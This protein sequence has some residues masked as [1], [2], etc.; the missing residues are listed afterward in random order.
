M[1]AAFRRRLLVSLVIALLFTSAEMGGAREHGVDLRIN[2]RGLY[3]SEPKNVVTTSIEATNTAD[4]AL[5]FLLDCE[6]P[7]NWKLVTPSF[8]FHLAPNETNIRPVC[9]FIPETAVAGTYEIICRVHS[10]VYPAISDSV[11]LNVV[12]RSVSKLRAALHTVPETVIAGRGYEAVFSVTNAGNTEMSVLFDVRSGQ[13]IPH[14]IEPEAATLAPG[15]SRAVTVSVETDEK[16]RRRLRHHLVL[17]ARSEDGQ[18]TGHAGCAVD[19]IPRITG[20]ADPFHRIPSELTFKWLGKSN[21]AERAGVQGEFFGRGMLSEDGEE[22]IAFL[23]RGPDTLDISSVFGRRDRYWAEYRGRY[24]EVS[25]GDHHVSLSPLIE[26]HFA[27]RGF[28]FGLNS[29]DFGLRGYHMNTRWLAA[30]EKETAVHLDYRLSGRHRLGINL[31]RHESGCKAAHMASLQGKTAPFE[32]A[33]IEFEAAYGKE[34]DRHGN[35]Y[36]FHAYGFPCRQGAC[37]V[38][39]MYAAPDF[40]GYYRNMELFSADLFFPVKDHLTMSA[41]VRQEKNNLEPDSIESAALNR[42]GRLGLDY[43]FAGGTRILLE[44][45]YRTRKDRSDTPSFDELDLTH[46]LRLAKGFEDVFVNLSAE[47]GS[48]KDRLKNRTCTTREYEGS[49][50]L[51]P[52]H[53]YSFGAYIRYSTCRGLEAACTLRTCLSGTFRIGRKAGVN[54]RLESFRRFESDAGDGRSLDLVFNYPI[55]KKVHIASFGRHTVYGR[56]TEKEDETAVL[57]QFTM[58]LG[59][60]AGRKKSVGRI[61]GYVRD[62]ETCRPVSNAVLRLNGATAVTDGDGR[63]LF[64]ALKPGTYY[65]D[66]DDASIG[67][68]RI[69]VQKTPRKI[70]IEGGETTS[71]QVGITRSARLAGRINVFAVTGAHELKTD[72]GTHP[73]EKEPAG[74]ADKAGIVSIGGLADAAVHL[75]NKGEALHVLTDTNGRFRFEDIRPGR[76]TLA[77]DA[78]TLPPYHYFENDRYA[79]DLEPGDNEEVMIR[80]LPK[81][82]TLTIIEHGGILVEEKEN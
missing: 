49:C 57:V 73:R 81:R 9:F 2:G 72:G 14:T 10:I 37:R 32:T 58:A 52:G 25:L 44:S 68:D 8:P 46:M 13:N 36:R 61:E 43:R 11:R 22:E 51:M 47:L 29:S 71:I 79:I 45:R 76:W 69:P 82:R 77:V 34:G 48:A 59:L 24:A 16:L 23:F 55:S 40:P 33:N 70:T 38:E 60:P 64:P 28:E 27:G 15:R 50:F 67:L 19:V 65:L 62:R 66:V 12:V 74:E 21:E 53:R 26:E 6:L 35:A 80:A 20:K 17:R 56:H 31:C 42:Y 30:E 63:F 4:E 18:T 3:E 78:D 5:D 1:T 7:K 75:T 39:Y 54:L 41:A